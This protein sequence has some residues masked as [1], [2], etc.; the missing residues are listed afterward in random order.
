MITEKETYEEY[1]R[2]HTTP[3]SELLARLN[4]ETH[5]KM[6]YP[7]MLSG[8]VMGSFL[9]MIC[10]MTKPGLV[11]E[12]GTFTA[13]SALYMAEG[14]PEDAMLHTIEVNPEQEEI[15][16]RYIR[17][18]GLEHKI[19]VHYGKAADIIPRFGEL[20]DLVFID[21]N[22]EDYPVYYKMLIGKMR[23]G[24]IILADNTFWGGK[25][26]DPKNLND[27]E[28]RGILEFNEMVQADERVENV[29]LPFR[30]GVMMIRKK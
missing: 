14:L 3:E 5:L 17:E 8:Q 27:R 15:I 25:I 28:T 9:K 26:F 13:Y 29:M 10:R 16:S 24:G 30:D 11:L 21:A 19:T 12:I 1:S 20:F 6:V 4:R 18:S 7:R 2:Q 22:K 23:S